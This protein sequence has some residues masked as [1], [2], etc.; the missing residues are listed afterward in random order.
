MA[1][2]LHFFLLYCSLFLGHDSSQLTVS[3][4]PP[5]WSKYLYLLYLSSI[6]PRNSVQRTNECISI[7]YDW[8]FRH[9]MPANQILKQT[10]AVFISHSRRVL[11]SWNACLVHWFF[12]AKTCL[13]RRL[14]VFPWDCNYSC[15][16][17]KV[18]DTIVVV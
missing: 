7:S 15:C 10:K 8:M 6:M 3:A 14:L 2:S 4:V 11:L 12:T 13:S 5:W 16:I 1:T 18:K 9:S 17:V